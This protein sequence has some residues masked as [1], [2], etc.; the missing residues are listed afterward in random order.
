[1]S[2][3]RCRVPC[4]VCGC[5]CELGGN[6]MLWNKH[7]PI[8]EKQQPSNLATWE[9]I[10]GAKSG[11]DIA[12]AP[13]RMYVCNRPE[14]LKQVLVAL[15]K[16]KKV[17][18][19]LL[20]VSMDQLMEK[21]PQPSTLTYVIVV[22]TKVDL[23][24]STFVKLTSEGEEGPALLARR[25]HGPALQS[26]CCVNL[27]RKVANL[28]H[29]GVPRMSFWRCQPVREEMLCQQAFADNGQ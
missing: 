11:T 9:S 26:H 24:L 3:C 2:R 19:S 17:Q 23:A 15:R 22:C 14:Y 5:A 20:I 25:Q 29:Y 8:I 13:T 21:N 18:H 10:E 1:M 27:C 12:Y 28:C 16:V 6:N 4:G 7:G